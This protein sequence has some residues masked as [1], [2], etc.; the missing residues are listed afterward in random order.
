MRYL[1]V[2]SGIETASLAWEPLGWTPIAFAEIDAFPSAVLAHRFPHVPNLGDFTKIEAAD[3]GPID[4]LVGGTPCQDFSV[5]GKRLGLDGARGNLAIEF[6]RLA[7]RLR[8]RWVVWE[9]VPGVHSNWSGAPK[10][11]DLAPGGC[12]EGDEDNDFG[13]F[14]DA[15]EE[16]GYSACWRNLDAQH[17][18]VESHPWA[19]PQRRERVLLVGYLGDWRPPAAV[20]LEPEGLRGDP[21]PRRQAGQAVAG[22]L[23]AGS[24]RS[25]GRV[26]RREAAANHLIGFSS[27]KTSVDA[28][29]AHA[30]TLDAADRGHGG[31]LAIAF[32]GNNT[33]GPVEVATACNAKGGAGRMDFESETFI[34]H[35]LRGGGF[36]ALEDGSGRGTPIV[37]VDLT[38][39][40]MGGDVAGTLEHAQS[41]SNRGQAIAF[42]TTQITSKENRCQPVDGGPCHPLAAHA[43]A[44]APALAFHARQDPDSGPVTHPLDTD[45]YSIGVQAGWAVRRLTPLECERLQGVPDGW[46][47]IPYRGKRAADGPRYRSLGNSMAV[48]VMSWVGQR[49][50]LF[51]KVRAAA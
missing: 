10:S 32:G 26:G 36:D 3:V 16:C 24:K 21:P 13:A 49:I 38:N 42:D 12:W 15:L 5:A 4:L 40:I 31:G 25:G 11:E 35:T 34:A 1:S 48:N 29:D 44:H 30:P 28:A 19:V 23:G 22:S 51:E 7:R 27:R 6:C 50:D 33:S 8:P 39:G 17:V 41:K 46:T 14:L 43:H 37:H 9:N 20:L 2:C 45:G 47:D 18:R